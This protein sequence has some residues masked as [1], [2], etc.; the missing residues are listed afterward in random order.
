MRRGWLSLKWAEVASVSVMSRG[1]LCEMSRGCLCLC[2]E[3]RLTLSV[4]WAEVDSVSI[5]RR[6]WLCPCNKQRLVLNLPLIILFI[7]ITCKL[8]VYMHVWVCVWRHSNL[9]LPCTDLSS[10]WLAKGG[11]FP[12]PP[13]H[14]YARGGQ[15]TGSGSI[16]HSSIQQRQQQFSTTWYCV[17]HSTGLQQPQPCQQKEKEKGKPSGY[18]CLFVCF[19]FIW[20][21]KVLDSQW[22]LRIHVQVLNYL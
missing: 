3:Q 1:W 21:C 22:A 2:S 9:L 14:P 18:F 13:H 7:P 12:E 17:C 15:H 4:K 16:L 6:G 20:Y 19:S 8:C 5:M 10:L 11:E